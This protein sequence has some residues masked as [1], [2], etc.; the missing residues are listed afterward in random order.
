MVEP[1]HG[2]CLMLSAPSMLR[3][4]PVRSNV[5]D[6]PTVVALAGLR[7][8]RTLGV[9]RLTAGD[10]DRAGAAACAAAVAALPRSVRVLDVQD[11]W[12]ACA[13]GAALVALRCQAQNLE[14]RWGYQDPGGHLDDTLYNQKRLRTG[15]EATAEDVRTV[16]GWLGSDWG[17]HV[18]TIVL[19]G[20]G[21]AGGACA[22][23]SW[24]GLRGGRAVCALLACGPCG[25][26]GSPRW[27]SAT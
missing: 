17:D 18:E 25:R 15:K 21:R 1:P 19:G 9:A 6:R 22:Q 5:L 12:G 13:E 27:Q 23:V 3:P 24:G 2:R 7:R 10:L 4:C 14:L 11:G 26:W 16:F 8:L 20:W